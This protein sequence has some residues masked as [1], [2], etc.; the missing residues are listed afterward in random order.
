MFL[1]IF[2]Y[3]LIAAMCAT[4]FAMNMAY[5]RH[6]RSLAPEERADDREAERLWLQAW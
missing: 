4:V 3:A 1:D 5:H 6:C 2:I